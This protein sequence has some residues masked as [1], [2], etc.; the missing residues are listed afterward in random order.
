MRRPHRHD[1]DGA[2]LV[3]TAISKPSTFRP[4]PYDDFKNLYRA[5][6]GARRIEGSGHLPSQ[7]HPGLRVARRYTQG[8]DAQACTGPVIDPMRSV[9]ERRPRVPCRLWQK[10]DYWTQEGHKTLYL[11][12]SFLPVPTGDGKGTVDRAIEFFHAR[13]PER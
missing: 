11:L 13:G 3:D 7:Q 6:L 12:V 4:S 5:S 9:I 10:I 2:T 8:R 1:G